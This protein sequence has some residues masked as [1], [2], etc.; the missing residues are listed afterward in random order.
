MSLAQKENSFKAWFIEH[1][2][3]FASD[4]AEHGADKGYLHITYTKDCVELHDRFKEEIWEM[5]NED[6][7]SFGY[8]NPMELVNTFN[9]VDMADSEDGLKNLLVWY[10]CE[11]VAQELENELEN[12][13]E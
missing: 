7:N 13:T 9:R 10:A 12:E 8:K 11:R 4:I 6:S 5:L 2:G 1:L 3:E